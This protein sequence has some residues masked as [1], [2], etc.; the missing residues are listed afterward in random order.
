MND[1]NELER[2][3][4]LFSERLGALIR[5]HGVQQNILADAIGVSESTVGKWLLEKALPRM[6]AIQKLADYFNVP[7]SYFLI[8][9]QPQSKD[10]PTPPRKKGVKIPVLGTVAA[11]VPIEAIE[12]IIDYEEIPESLARKGQFFGL[13]IS[14]QSM[15][16]TIQEG[17]VII[18]KWEQ[19]C[20]TGDIAVVVV[21]GDE[22]TV[23][24]IKRGFDGVTLIG[25]N[26]AVFPPKF[27]SNYEIETLPVRVIGVVYEVRRKFKAYREE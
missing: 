9:E 5:S 3:K 16:P 21:N 25:H 15:E 1:I 11:G 7:K 10:T 6:G 4:K 27:Y 20:D 17:D 26:V 23:K 8:E 2:A 14:G 19:T 22:A 18:C 13:V 12:N 24:E